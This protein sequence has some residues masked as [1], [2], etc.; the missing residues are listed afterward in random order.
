MKLIQVRYLLSPDAEGGGD[1]LDTNVNDIDTS[2]PLLP[3]TIYELRVEKATTEPTS[4]GGQQ[5]VMKMKTTQ[6]TTSVKGDAVP[7]GFPLTKR[8]AV[9]E[10]PRYTSRQI[11]QAIARVGKGL[12]VNAT[13][14]EIINSPTMLEGKIATWNVTIRKATAE[15]PNPSNDVGDPV[16]RE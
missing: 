11:G 15:Y 1:P 3:A 14:R 10:T 5:I 12:G 9:T 16:T 8:I 6:E 2:F 13:P 7:A 4:K